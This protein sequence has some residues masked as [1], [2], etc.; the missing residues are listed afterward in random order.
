MNCKPGDLAVIVRTDIPG[1][2][3]LVG[4]LVQCIS[5]DPS[6][7]QLY[8][9]PEWNYEA[10]SPGIP[11]PK[12]HTISDDCLR[13]IRD[14]GEDAKD[15]TLLWLPVPMKDSPPSDTTSPNKETV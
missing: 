4:S 1:Q 11:D 3:A 10:V 2:E 15:E 13:P 12:E 7:S 5:V 8:G 6:S 14:P 9:G